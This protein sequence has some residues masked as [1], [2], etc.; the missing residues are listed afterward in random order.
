VGIRNK[1]YIT[2][3]EYDMMESF[4]RFKKMLSIDNEDIQRS[5]TASEIRLK[6]IEVELKEK[7]IN[8][9]SKNP[10]EIQMDNYLKAL[11]NHKPGNSNFNDFLSREEMEIK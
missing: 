11:Y 7:I 5:L 3:G 1:I 8:I 10:F 2:A 9:K 4:D 6:Q